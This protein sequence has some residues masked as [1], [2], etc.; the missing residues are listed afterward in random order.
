MRS[1][2]FLKWKKHKFLM[3]YTKRKWLSLTAPLH[4][5]FN[6]VAQIL[7][8]QTLHIYF[9]WRDWLFHY[10]NTFLQICPQY[11][12]FLLPTKGRHIWKGTKMVI[13][14]HKDKKLSHNISFFFIH[15]TKFLI[16]H[17]T[18]TCSCYK[19]ATQWSYFIV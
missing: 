10:V 16:S 9:G 4:L 12:E 1:Q 6:S 5:G 2:S 14:N 15:F 11:W 7:R 3:C 8:L 17:H 18:F 19:K 13:C